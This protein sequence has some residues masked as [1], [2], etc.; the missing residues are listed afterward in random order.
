MYHNRGDILENHYGFL[1]RY[2]SGELPT[3][4]LLRIRDFEQ[5]SRTVPAAS[6]V[7]RQAYQAWMQFRFATDARVHEN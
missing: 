7:N 5:L 2:L 3:N 6:A 4:S 1:R